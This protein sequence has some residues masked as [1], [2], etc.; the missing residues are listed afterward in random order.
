VGGFALGRPVSPEISEGVLLSC[1]YRSRLTL[2]ADLGTRHPRQVFPP[3]PAS[4]KDCT[5]LVVTPKALLILSGSLQA[6]EKNYEG[7]LCVEPTN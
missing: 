5:P 1:S 2:R 7:V 4:T 6:R 3:F